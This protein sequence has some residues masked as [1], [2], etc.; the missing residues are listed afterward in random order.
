MLHQTSF[1]FSLLSVRVL[2]TP[3]IYLRDA[4]KVDTLS[5]DPVADLSVA[6]AYNR[7][8]FMVKRPYMLICLL[9]YQ[10]HQA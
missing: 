7:S 9:A 1:G 6:R 2:W 4:T 5:A 8:I 3:R 10:W